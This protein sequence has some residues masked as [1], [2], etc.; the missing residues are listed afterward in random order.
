MELDRFKAAWQHQRLEGAASRPLEDIMRDVRGRAAKF[1]RQIR[2][3]DLL[4]TLAGVVVIVT[5]SFFAWAV[6]H[7]V[8]KI[9]AAVVVA[10]G[11][12]I[13]VR[14]YLARTRHPSLADST[15][16]EFCANELKRI[17]E[18]IHLL[19]TVGWWYLAPLLGGGALFVLGGGGSIGSRVRVLA[20]LAAVGLIIYKL[21]RRAAERH[22]QPMRD[23]LARILRD[24]TA[25]EP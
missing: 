11:L 13:T 4:E 6:P 19:A 7:V 18:Q 15:A 16:R 24:M 10:G 20:V 22:L 17:D 12:L 9:G 23:D 21:N 1:N 14:L 8:A 2:Q 3:R 5:F 25:P